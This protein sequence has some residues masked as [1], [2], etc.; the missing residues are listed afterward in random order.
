[1][2]K[3]NLTNGLLTV[4]CRDRLIGM[5]FEGDGGPATAGYSYF[6]ERLALDAAGN[7]FISDA[8]QLA[9]PAG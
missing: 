4:I 8:T 6:P 7:L 5:G 2:R 9:H 1:M 3:V